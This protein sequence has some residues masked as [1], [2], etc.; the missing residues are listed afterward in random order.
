MSGKPAAAPFRRIRAPGC[1]REGSRFTHPT[2][3][4]TSLDRR[5][6]LAAQEYLQALLGA[7]EQKSMTSVPLY[8]SRSLLTQ[9][10][11]MTARRAL[12]MLSRSLYNCGGFGS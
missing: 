8:R 7:V 11:F 5:G 2:D 9:F 6:P 4:L 3:T 1:T 10:S 12:Y